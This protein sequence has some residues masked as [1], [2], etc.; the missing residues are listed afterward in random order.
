MERNRISALL[1]REGE[2]SLRET[3]GAVLFL[4][5]PAILE[6]LMFTAVQYVDTAMVGR[7]GANATAAVGVT[8]S[9]IWLFNGLFAAASIGFS[10]Q[11]A[12]LLGAGR[13]AEARSVTAQSLRFIL[14]F[15]VLAGGAGVALS[16]FLPDLLGAAPD[17]APDAGWYFRIIAMGMPFMLGTNMIS[18]ILRCAGDARSPM[19]LNSLINVLNMI[20]NFFLIYPTRT[21][22]IFGGEMRIPGAGLGVKGA[23]MASSLATAFI[24]CL[25]LLLLFRRPGPVQITRMDS[26]KL[27]PECLR[28]ALRLGLP[29]AME[30]GS[31][32]LAQILITGMISGIGTVAMAAN[33]L[34]VTAE[35][36]SYSPAYGV[37]AAATA[38]VGQAAGAKKKNLAMRF[39]KITTYIGIA[40]MAAGGL[41]LFVLARPLIML[42]TADEEVIVLGTTVLRIV[43]FAEPLFGAAIVGSGALRG[44]GDSRAPF[45]ICL[46]TMWGVR[47]TLVLLLARP[48]GLVGVWLAMAAELTVRGVI[49]LVRM[50]SGRWLQGSVFEEYAAEA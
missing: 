41:L 34:A 27:Q 31:M 1:Q 23:A 14:L 47:I 46:G 25:F 45:L 5:W 9:S 6:Q 28:S 37:S 38:L 43:A 30:R 44:A 12:Q 8:S 3:I 4:A 22:D 39:A 21:V 29:V 2:P 33:H 11:V 15:G 24:F 48:L 17:V 26:S 32:C 10:V 13:T 35:S 36:I 19:L 42:F 18:A 7:L 40:L 50:F 20:L 16:F 49:F